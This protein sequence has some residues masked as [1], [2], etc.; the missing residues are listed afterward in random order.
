MDLLPTSVR[1]FALILMLPLLTGASGDLLEVSGH[2][3]AFGIGTVPYETRLMPLG[4][5]G[6]ALV[7]ARL[8]LKVNVT[9]GLTFS[10]DPTLT[11][12]LG[13]AGLLTTGVGLSAPELLPLTA[14]LVSSSTLG[15]R[16][17][18]DRA[19][20]RAELGPVRLTVGRQPI[21]FGQGLAFTPMDLIAP[22]NPAVL[23]TSYK[24]G[25]DAVRADVF[26]GLTGQ[27]SLLA[28]YLGSESLAEIPAPGKEVE[29]PFGMDDMAVAVHGQATAGTVDLSVFLGAVYGDFVGGVSFYAPIGA[30]GLYGDVTVTMVRRRAY[31]RA[32]VGVMLR[33]G[34]TTTVTAEVYG[35]RFG[36]T[37]AGDYLVMPTTERYTRGELWLSGHLYAS[38]SLS[39][40]IT[41]LVSAS[42]V[43]I[44]NLL[45]P[46]ALLVGNVSW[47]VASNA[48]LSAGVQMGVGKKPN[49]E[50]TDPRFSSRS[51]FGTIPLTGF[52]NL[53]VY[54]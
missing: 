30:V 19:L 39:Q 17:R 12:T 50:L 26:L 38:V 49:E 8:K 15:L 31:P 7:D 1:R 22:F 18:V 35:Q 41:P 6:S 48:D 14:Q 29:E 44:A 24:P 11:A 9:N 36:T 32:V 20:M 51:E 42:A 13:G 53:G 10:F 33:P 43:V 16:L 47:S 46:S 37:H 4:P 54:F 34:A 21:S 5:T 25:V 28:A 2:V 3:K 27:I 52:V 23:D 45:D 40:E